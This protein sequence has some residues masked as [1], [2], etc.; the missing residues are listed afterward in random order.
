MNFFTY[1]ICLIVLIVFFYFT[2]Y[3]SRPA[4]NQSGL[5]IQAPAQGFIN[6]KKQLIVGTYN[7]QTGK[8]E[9][10]SRDIKR[11]AEIIKEAD[12][13]GIQEVY[14]ASWLG[15][16]SQAEQIA[17]QQH[18]SDQAF[19]WLFAATR[20]RWLREHRGNALLSK[21]KVKQWE[22]EMLPDDTGK[23]F[24]NLTTAIIDFNGVEVAI[25][26]THL[27]TKKGREKQLATVLEKSKQF[28]TA[29]LMGDFNTP[30]SNPLIKT[31]LNETD[32]IDATALIETPSEFDKSSR[33]DWI[34]S[35]G[36]IVEEGLF[37]PI[38]VSDHP[39]YQVSLSLKN[40]QIE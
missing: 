32:F 19:G 5:S 16:L 29:I 27:H 36:F 33:I 23:Q 22:V 17:L 11:S 14:A 26:V 20:M 39:Y 34:L 18:S 2:V 13:V 21:L 3:K 31:F 6:S 30:V 8:D 4:K 9:N 15:R 7:V 12:I 10:G 40:D 28:E 25:M 37:E 38:G 1:G 35:K 24:R